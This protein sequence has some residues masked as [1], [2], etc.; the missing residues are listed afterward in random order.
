MYGRHANL[1]QRPFTLVEIMVSMAALLLIMSFLFEFVL[2][3]QRIYSASEHHAAKF[4]DA[5][6]LLDVIGDDIRNLQYSNELGYAKPI[7][8]A[9]NISMNFEGTTVPVAKAWLFITQFN[10][11]RD[12]KAL[13]VYPVLYAYVGDQED[14]SNAVVKSLSRTVLRLPL[15]NTS[16]GTGL[17]DEDSN[18]LTGLYLYP[19]IDF[20][21]DAS[22]NRNNT[23][24]QSF[25]VGLAGLQFYEKHILMS[26][27]NDFNLDFL[28]PYDVT[29]WNQFW[30]QRTYSSITAE[31]AKRQPRGVQLKVS[32]FSR[33]AIPEELWAEQDTAAKRLALLKDYER[34]FTKTYSLDCN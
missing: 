30:K 11:S 14:H 20:G 21:T 33:D 32:V 9:S 15:V 23:N 7:L 2:S 6:T 17:H 3:S 1:R 16:A 19:L 24:I 10:D 18:S 13:G 22:V 29:N 25:V 28:P 5:Q 27:V 8:R 12:P 34:S 31:Y 4:D 26:N